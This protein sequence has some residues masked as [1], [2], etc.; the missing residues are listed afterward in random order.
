MLHFDTK[1]NENFRNPLNLAKLKILLS[2]SG[3]I[4]ATQALNELQIRDQIGRMELDKIQ[5][6]RIAS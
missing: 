4:N 2:I 5:M 3:P 1:A 6:S